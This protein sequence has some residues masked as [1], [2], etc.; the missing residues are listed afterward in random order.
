MS[1]RKSSE[2]AAVL[3]QGQ[4]VRQMTDDMY[5]RQIENDA[6]SYQDSVRQMLDTWKRAG[7][8]EA[9][10][11]PES[12]EIFGIQGQRLWEE[13]S[14]LSNDC[15]G[16]QADMGFGERIR[17][18][19]KKLDAELQSADNEAASIRQAISRKRNG[20]YC[21]D[22]YRRAEKLVEQYKKLRDARIALGRE[23]G[24]ASQN[25]RQKMHQANSDENRLRGLKAQLDD[26]NHAARMQR[27]ADGMREK[28]R[29]TFGDIDEVSAKKFL[30]DAY[31]HLQESTEHILHANTED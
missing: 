20:W 4:K 30:P 10:F 22:E 23:I 6:R 24:Q 15:R 29:N 7:D 12:R 2:V 13:F 18:R 27:E 17:E 14:R 8:I 26:M 11:A 9:E 28:I 5:A 25:A 3:E 21:D 31:K 1:G 19:L 16:K